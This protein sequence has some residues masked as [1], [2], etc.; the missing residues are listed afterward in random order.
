[1]SLFQKRVVLI[2]FLFLL[3]EVLPRI[4]IIDRLLIPP[5]STI[6]ETAYDLF[7]HGELWK[8]SSISLQRALVGLCAAV[9]LGLP[10]GL[11]LGGWFPRLQQAVEPLMELFAQANP[12]ILAHI[13]IFFLGVGEVAR[14]FIIGWLCIW[15]I[16]FCAISGIHSVDQQ[17]LKSARSFGLGRFR[18]FFLVVIP[19]SAPSIFTGVRLAAGYAFIMLV[20][21]EMM[22]ANTGLGY[23]IVMSQESYKVADVF[24]G[25]LIVTLFAVVTDAVIR[26]AEKRVVIWDATGNEDFL[27]LKQA[28]ET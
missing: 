6:L 18:L 21:S 28:E 24:A 4:G 27:N 11:L 19:A 2:L 23:F 22:G 8:H 13:I 16:I 10:A 25:T 1:M 5:L 17:L 3:W 14:T 12:V 20:A 9:F 26:Y 7:A 15:P